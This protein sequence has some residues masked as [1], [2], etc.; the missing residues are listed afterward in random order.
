VELAAAADTAP[1][2]ASIAG[3][4]T[5]STR[6]QPPKIF[7]D[8]GALFDARWRLHHLGVSIFWILFEE[9]PRKSEPGKPDAGIRECQFMFI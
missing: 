7:F 4:L 3:D 6:E 9:T 5:C 8:P 2:V 1:V